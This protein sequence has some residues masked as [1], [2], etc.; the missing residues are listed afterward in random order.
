MLTKAHGYPQLGVAVS[1]CTRESNEEP[2]SGI[3]HPHP[4]DDCVAFPW[5]TDRIAYGFKKR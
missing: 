2:T 1:I 4:I 3:C 5:Y